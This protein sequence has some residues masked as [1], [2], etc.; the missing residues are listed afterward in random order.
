MLLTISHGQAS[1]ERGYSVNNELLVENMQEK[2]VVTLRT[3][4]D[5]IQ[6]TGQHFTELPFTPRLKRHVRASRMRYQQYLADQKKSQTDNE[7]SSKRKALQE[8]IQSAEKKRKLLKD[9]ME[10]M[11]KEADQ[12]AKKA[13]TKHDFT[14]LAK[15]NA[16]RQKV[17]EKADE[18]LKL[19]KKLQDLK[20]KLKSME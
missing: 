17:S 13:E 10:S 5:S 3:V 8:D 4:Y 15:S 20:Q 16:F 1:V 7:K 19:E 18:Y 11:T 12:L 9:S 2:T 6:A 14:L